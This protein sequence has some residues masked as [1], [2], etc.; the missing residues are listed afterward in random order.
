MSN[1]QRQLEVQVNLDSTNYDELLRILFI[2]KDIC[3]DVDIRD[4]FIRQRTDDSATIFE[5]DLTD[6][7][8]NMSLPISELKNKLDVFKCFAG[9]EV[10]ITT[11]EDSFVISDQYS[12]LKIKKPILEYMDNKFIS[13]EE[14]SRVIVTN[15]EDLILSTQISKKISD[16]MKVI[17][18]SFHINSVQ[19]IIN[20]E[21]AS[22][23]CSTQSKDNFAEFVKNIVSNKELNHS[24]N[25]VITPFVIDHDGDINFEMYDLGNN[26]VINSFSTTVGSISV[27]LYTRAQ[28]VENT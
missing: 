15:S 2:L 6:I 27:N 7:I 26:I 8:S 18:S 10:S 9:Q 4:G 23:S 19:S 24:A 11:T 12:V 14:L 1:E 16:R 13:H 22:I 25:L 17:S 28:M 20:G 21:T 3:N 5:V